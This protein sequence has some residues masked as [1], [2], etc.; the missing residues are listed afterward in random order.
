M[1]VA[2]VLTRNCLLQPLLYLKRCLS[3]RKVQAV[4]H[5][6]YMRVDGDCRRVK[7][8]AHHN[9]RRLSP[10]PWKFLQC[11]KICGSLPAV[12]LQEDVTRLQNVF[13]LHMEKAT[14]MDRRL[15]FFL[16]ECGNRLGCIRI[17]EK[18]SR[19]D[20]YAHIRTLRRKNHRDEELERSPKFQCRF[21]IGIEFTKDTQLL[22]LDGFCHSHISSSANASVQESDRRVR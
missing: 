17:L 2:P 8:D 14:V 10:D 20:V 3:D 12:L 11:L 18:A 9:I 13:C 19:H 7:R 15:K 22:C 1:C 6:K 21:C 16:S 5:A 4:R